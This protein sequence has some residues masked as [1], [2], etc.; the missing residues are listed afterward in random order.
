VDTAVNGRQKSA[1]HRHS[2]RAGTTTVCAPKLYKTER[3]A[4]LSRV[5]SRRTKLNS[6]SEN[7]RIATAVFT[8]EVGELKLK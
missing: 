3:R 8:L 2:L 4:F 7:T 6:S 5:H 1:R